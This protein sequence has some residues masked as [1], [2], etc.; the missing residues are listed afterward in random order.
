M[1]E[2]YKIFIYFFVLVL[3]LSSI[4]LGYDYS[5]YNQDYHH[6]FFILSSIIDYDKGL[7]LF[8]EI[9]LQYGPGQI[10]FFQFFRKFY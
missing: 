1:S 5:V 10:F 6:T 8:E 4:Y 7:K 3:I 9:F 2:K